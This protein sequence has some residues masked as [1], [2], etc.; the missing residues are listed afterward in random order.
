MAAVGSSGWAFI[1]SNRRITLGGIDELSSEDLAD[2]IERLR[3]T[4]LGGGMH[5]NICLCQENP[6]PPN[7]LWMRNPVHILPICHICLYLISTYWSLLCMDI[8]NNDSTS[9]QSSNWKITL[10]SANSLTPTGI[11]EELCQKWDS[12][13]NCYCL[14]KDR[15]H[16]SSRHCLLLPK[17]LSFLLYWNRDFHWYLNYWPG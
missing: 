6:N 7:S 16:T 9:S 1:P 15:N 13:Y 3:V 2:A 10:A 14:R 4:G 5:R 11:K 8:F 17:Q 12:I